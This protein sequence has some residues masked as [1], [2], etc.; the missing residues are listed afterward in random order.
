[1]TAHSIS[2]LSQL[3]MSSYGPHT[4]VKTRSAL[5]NLRYQL[6]SVEGRAKCQTVP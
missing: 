5:V 6:H 4:G 3:K 2:I 1:M